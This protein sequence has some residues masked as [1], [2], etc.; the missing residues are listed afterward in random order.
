MNDTTRLHGERADRLIYCLS[1]LA[2]MG[3]TIAGVRSVQR[4]AREVLHIVLGT[5]GASKGALLTLEGGRFTLTAARGATTGIVIGR[6]RLLVQSLESTAGTVLPR[7]SDEFP[8]RLKQFCDRRFPDLHTVVAVVLRAQRRIVGL[9]LL[10]MRFMSQRYGDD[11]LRIL[12]MIGR[13]VS[14][15]LYNFSLR[16][17]AQK[18]AFQLSHKVLQ[19]ESLHDIGLSVASLKPKEQLLREA[20]HGSISL[21]D[22]RTAFYMH[23]DRGTLAIGPHIGIDARRIEGFVA[24]PTYARK[25]RAGASMRLRASRTARRTLGS[26]T[27]L[28][29][30]VKTEKRLFGTLVVVGKER[31]EGGDA[32]FTADDQKLLAAFA[33]QAAVALRNLEMQAAIIEKERFAAELETA[34][35]IQRRIVPAPEDLP[36]IEGFDIHGYNYPCREVGGDYFD[37]IPLT[38][39]RFAFIICD[40]SGKGLSAA[41]LVSTLQATFHS[42]LQSDLSLVEIVE[43]AN[44]LLIRNTTAEKYA[45]AFIGI[46]DTAAGCMETVNAGHNE[47][48]LVHRSGEMEKLYTG[49][50]ILGMFDFAV[51]ESRKIALAS[52]DTIYLYTDGISEALDSGGEEFGDARLAALV[53]AESHRPPV[54]ILSA[55]ERRVCDWTGHASPAEG[56]SHDDFTH[57][58]IQKG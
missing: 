36:C 24:H 26:P 25:F 45:T 41:L 19:L 51:Y 4:S 20:L 14:V 39:D 54:D 27:L 29:A 50:L 34:V 44:R 6:D 30:P 17:N 18:A 48:L 9:L 33:T 49:G 7:W 32:V 3:E 16:R 15:A 22:A 52:G 8:D 28:A 21:L 55:I 38:G 23:H 5:M 46:A 43:R 2:D 56:F 58:A 57:L 31:K 35:A 53:R 12:E 11:D 13:H 1:S 47:P 40:V 37:V 42:L 10:S